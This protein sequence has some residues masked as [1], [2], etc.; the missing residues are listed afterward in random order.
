MRA[1]ACI[2]YL[3]TQGD[4]FH[5]FSVSGILVGISEGFISEISLIF[6][7]CID[8]CSAEASRKYLDKLTILCLCCPIFVMPKVLELSNFLTLSGRPVSSPGGM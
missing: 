1:I 4:I 3:D 6:F 5:R 2:R 7:F 8:N